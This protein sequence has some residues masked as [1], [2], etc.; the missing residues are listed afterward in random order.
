MRVLAIGANPD[1]LEFLCAGTL[2]KCRQRG[3]E[4]VMCVST[5]GS[6]GHFHIL[7]P[8]L[9]A[10]R[11]REARQSADVLGAEI[12]LLDMP[13][14]GPYPEKHQ[15]DIYVDLIRRAN[16]D[17]ILTHYPHDYM[18]DHCYTSTNTIDASF[19]C[20]VPQYYTETPGIDHV[21]VVYFFEPI[22]GLGGFQPAEWVDITDVWDKKVEMLLSHQSQARWLAEHDGIDYAEFM[23]TQ[24]RYRGMQCGVKYAEAFMPM[25]RWPRVKPYRML[26]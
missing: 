17:L 4:I 24:A 11:R 22:G 18:S 2:L 20:C 3:D 21:P 14:A 6:M 23:A 25:Q 5:N 9:S 7:T 12:M 13:D 8:H 16:P 1:D 19:W 10:I 15:R 26:P